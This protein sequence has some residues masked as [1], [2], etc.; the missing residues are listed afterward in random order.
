M[1]HPFAPRRAVGAW[2]LLCASAALAQPVFKCEVAGKATYQSE[3]CAT[4]KASAVTIIG[5]PSADDAAAARQRALRDK[6][7]AAS[8]SAPPPQ[9]A[10]QRQYTTQSMRRGPADCA[11]MN[12]QRE[13]A[14]SQRNRALN[15]A[16]RG[17]G[18]VTAGSRQDLEIGRMNMDIDS[19]ES[20]MR[21]QGCTLN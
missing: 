15:G 21:A 4:G 5:G 12:A 14:Y 11:A 9:P 6:Q 18:G 13:R 10:G 7:D 8:L 3:P 2:L 19:L 16:R 17:V 20:T 1:S